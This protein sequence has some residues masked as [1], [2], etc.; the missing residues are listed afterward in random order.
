MEGYCRLEIEHS[1]IIKGGKYLNYLIQDQLL[2]KE[3]ASSS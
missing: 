3:S 2:I 1:D